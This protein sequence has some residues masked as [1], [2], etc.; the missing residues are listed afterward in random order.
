MRGCVVASFQERRM[1]Y[2]VSLMANRVL[3]ITP[4]SGHTLPCRVRFAL[5]P[6]QAP[7]GRVELHLER[8]SDTGAAFIEAMRE[9]VA[10]WCAVYLG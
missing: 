6:A 2:F 3:E 5:R 7:L 8:V 1:S 4:A 9:P 10:R